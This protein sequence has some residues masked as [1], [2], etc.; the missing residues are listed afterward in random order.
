M[1]GLLGKQNPGNRLIVIASE[2]RDARAPRYRSL[3]MRC[4]IEVC[5]LDC[6]LPYRKRFLQFCGAAIG[7]MALRC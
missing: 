4:R 1:V 3:E 2:L 7:R 6:F 5:E